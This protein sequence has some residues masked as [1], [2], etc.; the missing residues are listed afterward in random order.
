MKLNEIVKTIETNK[1]KDICLPTGFS[2]LDKFLDGGF[3]RK[4][5]V[6]IGGGSGT[7]KSFIAGT[8]FKNIASSA[9]KCGYF[10]LEISNG[11]VVSRLIAQGSNI[12]FSRILYGFLNPDELVKIKKAKNDLMVWED[13]MDFKDDLYEYPKIEEEIRKNKYDFVVVDFIQNVI[14]KGKDEYSVLS[15]ISLRLQKLAKECNCCVLALSQLSNSVNRSG[16]EIAEF[17]G[18]SSI[19]NVCDLGIF[20]IRKVNGINIVND[21]FILKIKKNRRGISGIDFDF[22]FIQDGG[23][24]AEI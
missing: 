22:K 19:M 14:N 5:L 2:K 4:E 21:E 16:G 24:I 17:K 20:L 13:Y 9:F 8:I 18:S 15:E 10:S 11:M 6:I 7:G 3:F 1:S 23:Q 12:K